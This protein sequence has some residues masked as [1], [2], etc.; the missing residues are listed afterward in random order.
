MKVWFWCLHCERAFPATMP[1]SA[2]KD[3]CGYWIDAPVKC[4]FEG[5]DGHIGDIWEWE[6]VLK[7]NPEYPETPVEGERY[8]LYPGEPSREFKPTELEVAGNEVWCVTVEGAAK[9][10]GLS[11]G[12]V[13]IRV[14]AGRLTKIPY[15]G[16]QLIP[17]REVAEALR[18]TDGEVLQK[19][20]ELGLRLTLIGLF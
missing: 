12:K 9:L 15:F 3:E 1:D 13:R 8:A 5:C 2:R 11:P 16:E 4:A 17:L 20:Q 14:L 6:L 10:L 18:Q 19:A 7:A